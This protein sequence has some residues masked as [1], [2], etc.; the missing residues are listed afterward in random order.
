D[1]E[2]GHAILGAS[3]E[4]RLIVCVARVDR[5]KDQAT[6]VR[7]WA[8]HCAKD[9]DLA[10]VGP[11]T[12]PG[13]AQELRELSAGAAGRLILHGPVE[14]ED[15]CHVYAAADVSVLPSRHEPFG[16]TCLESWAA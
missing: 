12:S 6:L 14:P 8:R 13:Y 15:A 5:Q 9:C 2:R 1:A 11:E 4:R 3:K 10:L 7:A 16:L